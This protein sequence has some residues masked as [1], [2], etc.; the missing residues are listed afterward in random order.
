MGSRRQVSKPRDPAQERSAARLRVASGRDR[1]ILLRRPAMTVTTWTHSPRR[2]A[3][4]R[5]PRRR[6]SHLDP[7]PQ[8]VVR[9]AVLFRASDVV[10]RRDGRELHDDDVLDSNAVKQT[11]SP[12]VTKRVGILVSGHDA[13]GQ[14]STG[15][16]RAAAV[17][18]RVSIGERF[19]PAGAVAGT[20]RERQASRSGR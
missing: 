4:Q 3:R 7:R 12:R 5:L 16:A 10:N 1:E 9:P 6:L 2:R 15:P 19:E 11:R 8:E 18:R 20:S 14:T 17:K 13:E